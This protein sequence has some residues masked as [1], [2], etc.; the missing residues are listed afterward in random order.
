MVA[1]VRLLPALTVLW[2]RERGSHDSSRSLQGLCEGELP[3]PAPPGPGG[4]F[5]CS[6]CWSVAIRLWLSTCPLDWP[7]FLGTLR[8]ESVREGGRGGFLAFLRE[9]FLERDLSWSFGRSPWI[10]GG[11]PPSKTFTT[12]CLGFP[13]PSAPLPTWLDPSAESVR[14]SG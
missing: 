11:L 9:M 5:S 12:L 10:L 13:K 3:P 2:L 8:R 1:E 7:F 6:E 4:R 14:R